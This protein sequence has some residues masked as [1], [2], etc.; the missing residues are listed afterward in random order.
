M[1]GGGKAFS[2]RSAQREW[3]V[4]SEPAKGVEAYK[5]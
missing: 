5:V 2:K 4:L 3:T 1:R